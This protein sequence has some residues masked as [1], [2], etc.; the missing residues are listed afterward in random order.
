MKLIKNGTVM[1]HLFEKF[2]FLCIFQV[3][4]LLFIIYLKLSKIYTWKICALA[5]SLS[6]DN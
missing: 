5:F 3:Y 6:V 1:I 2:L 4:Y